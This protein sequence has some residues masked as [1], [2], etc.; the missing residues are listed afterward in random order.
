M[1]SFPVV[2][3]GNF[4]NG[5]SELFFVCVRFAPPHKQMGERKK[6][7]GTRIEEGLGDMIPELGTNRNPSGL[8][9]KP[10][11]SHHSWKREARSKDLSASPRAQH[12]GGGEK[13][14]AR[15]NSA[16]NPACGAPSSTAFG[17]VH[18][19]LK[20]P[21]PVRFVKLSSHRLS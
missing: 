7:M 14:V 13:K 10:A 21:Y 3:T 2:T 11:Y 5:S 1:R 19:W 16:A 6:G 18:T 20:A 8:A 12:S 15:H 9:F 4:W 17:Y